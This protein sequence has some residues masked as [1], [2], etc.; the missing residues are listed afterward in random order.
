VYLSSREE[1]KKKKN[2]KQRRGGEKDTGGKNRLP[3]SGGGGGPF[4]LKGGGNPGR[5]RAAKSVL[6][7]TGGGVAE[8]FLGGGKYKK[9]TVTRPQARVSNFPG[10][11]KKK[12]VDF[13]ERTTGKKVHGPTKGVKVKRKRGLCASEH[14]K[15]R[16]LSQKGK[17]P[18]KGTPAQRAT[19]QKWGRR[20]EKKNVE[21]E[22]RKRG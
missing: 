1:K 4:N 19:E 8:V 22:E 14:R 18:K 9:K 12:K 5:N 20:G 11:G 3:A 2:K 15:G 6:K 10:G 21:S 16:K 13:T 17:G 7:G